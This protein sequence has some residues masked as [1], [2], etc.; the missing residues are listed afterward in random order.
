MRYEWLL[1]D[2]AESPPC[3]P[4]LEATDP[5]YFN[6]LLTAESLLPAS[7]FQFER[8][9]IDL[10]SQTES[11]ANYLKQC[12]DLRLLCI[13]AKF[14]ILFGQPAAFFECILSIDH[15]LQTHWD[16]VYPRGEDGDFMLRAGAV[17]TLEDIQTSILP[18]EYAPLV[19]DRRH[20]PVTYRAQRVALGQI[21]AREG[22]TKLDTTTIIGVL[23]TDDHGEEVAR[24]HDL[25]VRAQQALGAI[26]SSFIDHIGYEQAPDF[27]G[28]LEAMKGV[29][30]MLA[31][32]RPDLAPA[33][34]EDDASPDG[35]DE[36]TP[37]GDPA[38]READGE[39]TFVSQTIVVSG[40]EIATPG[41]VKGALLAA[42]SYFA[43]NEPSNPALILVHQA[44]SLVGKSF[45]DA[46]QILVPGAVDGAK[47][48]VAANSDLQLNADQM[49]SL[50]SEA[51][52]MLQIT[53]AGEDGD[54]QPT[55]AFSAKIRPE[56]V[57]L[58]RHYLQHPERV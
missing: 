7:F 24:L 50:S 21:G 17:G 44:H 40:I 33:G 52:Q 1:E 38:Q 27:D 57:A 34:A 41:Q 43:N 37:S 42:A 20:G 2:T 5:D 18:L 31:E 30:D 26:R 12:R 28:L 49:R 55:H 16:E 4:D 6:F 23:A 36:A 25:A 9:S 15:L 39:M 22:E 3:G 29:L 45:V 58:I 8:S 47:L 19:T 35:T 13:E 46:M 56:A 10:R 51:L 32:A 14:R 48:K 11:I 53:D 54:N